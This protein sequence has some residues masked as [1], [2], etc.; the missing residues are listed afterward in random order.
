MKGIWRR[1]KERMTY[2]VGD[3]KEV[4]VMR[5][6]PIKINGNATSMQNGGCRL[7]P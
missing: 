3:Q 7:H 1:R 4:W 6:S 2:L 5:T